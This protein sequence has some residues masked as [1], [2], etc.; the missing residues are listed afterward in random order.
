MKLKQDSFETVLKL[1][2]FSFISLCGRFKSCNV[3][4]LVTHWTRSCICVFCLDVSYLAKAIIDNILG[5]RLLTAA[6]LPDCVVLRCR[7]THYSVV[8]GQ[9]RMLVLRGLVEH[10]IYGV[11]PS[12]L[13]AP[14]A[15]RRSGRGSPRHPHCFVGNIIPAVS[16]TMFSPSGSV[17]QFGRSKSTQIIAGSPL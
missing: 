7:R 13:W 11:L 8:V 6:L 1:F 16:S 10:E 15:E 9:F 5:Q 3:C 4:T 17:W 2:C 14:S 12:H